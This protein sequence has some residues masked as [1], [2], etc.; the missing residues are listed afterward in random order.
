MRM[1]NRLDF[2]G[3]DKSI[4]KQK[5]VDTAAYLFQK[6]G[7]RSTTLDDVSRELNITKAALYHY[8]SSKDELLSIIYTHTIKNIFMAGTNE[9]SG[10]GSPPDEKLK[11][12]IRN[13]IKNIIIESLP[14]FSVFFSEEN[15]LPEKDYQ[16]ITKEKRRYNRILEEI[17][18]EGVSKGVFKKADAKLQ[19]YAI[20]GMC[21][22]I[23][24]WYKP[25]LNR[26]SSDDIADHFVSL[27]ETGYLENK[28]LE[29]N[30][31]SRISKPAYKKVKSEDKKQTLNKLKLL[32]S[33]VI[34][35]IDEIEK[36]T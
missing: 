30:R 23:Y 15:Q 6:K 25:D 33:D 5:I 13:H 31:D 14:M 35:L 12:F 18:E 4:R 22:W 32:C 2:K 19:S 20:L 1:N 11:L 29:D 7:Y 28:F 26:Y 36:S 17:I 3:L 16:K 8:V 34:Q 24:K 10:L 27:L 21:N 9:V